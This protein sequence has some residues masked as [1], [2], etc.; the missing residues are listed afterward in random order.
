MLAQRILDLFHI[1]MVQDPSHFFWRLPPLTVLYEIAQTKEFNRDLH[2]FWA[3]I[4]LQLKTVQAVSGLKLVQNESVS[5][6]SQYI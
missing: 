3:W 2:Q 5:V 1:Y 4:H 6:G